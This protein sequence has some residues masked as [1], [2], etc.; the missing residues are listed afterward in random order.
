M[1]VVNA[2]SLEFHKQRLT[3]EIYVTVGESLFPGMLWN[4][5]V[6]IVLNWWSG[7]LQTL[8]KNTKKHVDLNFM[9]GPFAI[10]IVRGRQSYYAELF[11]DDVKVQSALRISLFELVGCLRTAMGEVLHSCYKNKWS[12]GEIE[13]LRRNKIALK[14]LE[15]ALRLNE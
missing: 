10:R 7:N 13:T 6:A 3:G 8:A 14:A 12:N 11:R 1:I 2:D 4:D 5:S 9:D 15:N